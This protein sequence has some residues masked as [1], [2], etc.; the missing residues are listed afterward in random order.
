MNTILVEC[1]RESTSHI[2]IAYDATGQRLTLQYG[3]VDLA[4]F[5]PIHCEA[6]YF[7]EYPELRN[8]HNGHTWN[9]NELWHLVHQAE[10]ACLEMPMRVYLQI[11]AQSS[12]PVIYFSP[13]A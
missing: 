2:L 4:Q 13:V 5:K 3:E 6:L 10:D 12:L 9:W 11:N 8:L 1:Q 7:R